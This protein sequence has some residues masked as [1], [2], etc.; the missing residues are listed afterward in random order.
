MLAEAVAPKTRKP[1]KLKAPK[2]V[3]VPLT[4]SRLDAAC[5]TLRDLQKA[6]TAAIKSRIIF[7]NRLLSQIC[8]VNGYHTGLEEA[9]RKAAFDKARAD[10]K[11]LETLQDGMNET[12]KTE[13]FLSKATDLEQLIVSSL[14][15]KATWDTYEDRIESKMESIAAQLPGADWLQTEE[16][17]GIKLKSM[18]TIVGEA[19]NLRNYSCVGKLWKRLGLATYNGHMPSTWR[20]KFFRE[21]MGLDALSA[22]EWTAIGYSP[23]RRSVMYVI[24]DCIMK[25][26]KTGPYRAKYD[27]AKAA[28]ALKYP[29]SSDQH[30]HRHGML[31]ATKKFV[32]HLWAHWKNEPQS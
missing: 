24:G 19:G 6:R 27:E 32:H 2:P 30:Y 14:N 1:R 3:I 26:N 12:E 22:E 23:R 17:K 13:W 21:K 9:E 4:I 16:C 8:V 29:D 5:N 31:C 11:A 10:M 25:L 20:S 28:F 7:T 18:A 15:E